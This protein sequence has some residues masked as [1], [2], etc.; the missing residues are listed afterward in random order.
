MIKKL[1][2]IGNRYA[3]II[4]QD[5]MDLLKITGKSS[6]HVT[7]KGQ[8]IIITPLPKGKK[9]ITFEAAV[10]LSFKRFGRAYKNLA[11]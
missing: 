7:T 9:P 1:T 2:K 4:D 5:I 8:S 6:L 3:L 10:E 11:G